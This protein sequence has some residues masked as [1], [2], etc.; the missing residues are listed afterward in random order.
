MAECR[1]LANAPHDRAWYVLSTARGK[2]ADVVTGCKAVGFEAFYPKC[3]EKR[4][5]VRTRRVVRP[6][7]SRYVF[8]AVEWEQPLEPLF[9]IR[10]AKILTVGSGAQP[11]VVSGAAIADMRARMDENGIVELIEDDEFERFEKG[12]TVKIR[13][14]P[15]TGFD[16]LYVARKGLRERVLLSLFGAPGREMT[17]PVGCL[18]KL[19]I[20]NR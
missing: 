12:E 14:G 7:I 19:D 3:I 4:G 18:E 15:L 13:Q 6:L 16:A 9:T 10:H 1:T 5:H 17:L 8:A 11:A 20:P 2:E